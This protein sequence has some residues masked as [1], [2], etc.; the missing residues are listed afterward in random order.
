MQTKAPK[1]QG[2]Q[3]QPQPQPQAPQKLERSCERCS[4]YVPE[5]RERPYYGE[6]RLNPAPVRKVAT[7]WCWQFT[8]MG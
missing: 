4:C 8:T 2:F 6:C 1:P 7:D 3:R 5:D